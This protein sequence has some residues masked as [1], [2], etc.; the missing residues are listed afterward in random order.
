MSTMLDLDSAKYLSP[1]ELDALLRS[2]ARRIRESGMSDALRSLFRESGVTD[3]GDDT[4]VAVLALASVI[5]GNIG[6]N[7]EPE[8]RSLLLDK[9]LSVSSTFD[10]GRNSI[11]AA[12]AISRRIRLIVTFISGP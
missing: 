10:I 7:M 6:S 1:D 8:P 9:L 4:Q 3:L 12:S 5:A 2:G 11:I